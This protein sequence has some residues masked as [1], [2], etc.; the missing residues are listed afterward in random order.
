MDPFI[1]QKAVRTF[2]ISFSVCAAITILAVVGSSRA[3]SYSAPHSPVLHP[4]GPAPVP[5]SLVLGNIYFDLSPSGLE[6]LMMHLE[7]NDL[8]AFKSIQSEVEDL[9]TNNRISNYMFWGGIAATISSPFIMA[10]GLERNGEGEFD[11]SRLKRF[12]MISTAGTI[13]GLIVTGASFIFRPGRSDY[14]HIINKHNQG[15]P[16]TPLRLQLGLLPTNQGR[17]SPITLLTVNF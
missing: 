17:L 14:L 8:A 9:Q 7:E 3:L 12:A 4:P 6:E 5:S 1:S 13:G 10:A 11:A 15:S 2:K 16:A